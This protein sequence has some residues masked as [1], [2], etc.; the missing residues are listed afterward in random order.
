MS[1]IIVVYDSYFGNTEKIAREIGKA[2][3]NDVQV[4]SSKEIKIE[5]L[6]ELD[7]FIVGATTRAFKPSDPIKYFLKTIPS[8]EL[9]GVKVASFDTRMDPKDVGNPILKFMARLFGYAAEPIAKPFP[10]AA[11]VLPS[12]SRASVFFRTSSPRPAISALPPA[13]SAIGP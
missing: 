9:N 13:L 10:V 6:S 4:K 11:V 2:L 1:K 5:M 12:E 3:G 7:Y 8:G